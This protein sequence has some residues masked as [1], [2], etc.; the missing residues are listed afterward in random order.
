MNTSTPRTARKSMRNQGSANEAL[1]TVT[2]SVFNPRRGQVRKSTGVRTSEN[3]TEDSSQTERTCSENTTAALSSLNS[4]DSQDSPVSS[5][6]PRRTRSSVGSQDTTLPFSQPGCSRDRDFS[7]SDEEPRSNKKTALYRSQKASHTS[8]A[9]SQKKNKKRASIVESSSSASS[10]TSEI[11]RCVFYILTAN[12]SKKAIKKRDIIQHVYQG[13]SSQ[14]FP[15]TFGFELMELRNS[16]NE[17]LLVNILSQQYD[18]QEFAEYSPLDCQKQGL[19]F[20]ILALI[21][22]NENSIQ[23]DEL[24]KA[25]EPLGIEVNK[26][27]PHPIFGDVEKYVTNNLVKEMYLERREI[28]KE[29]PQIELTWG[30]RAHKEVFKEDLLNF[31]CEIMPDTKPTDW[32]LQYKDATGKTGDDADQAEM[33]SD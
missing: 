23:E 26:R 27:K 30:E 22:M 11:N 24:W 9:A 33:E 7:D 25:L 13:E 14:T 6:Q 31:V 5:F 20:Y 10:S 12:K 32:I 2:S 3:N 28:S 16:K 4:S 17:Y 15:E 1:S 29:P 18:I 8:N 21:F 19:V